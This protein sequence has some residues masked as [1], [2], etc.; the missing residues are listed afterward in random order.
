MFVSLSLV[1]RLGSELTLMMESTEPSA[2]LPGR[3][4]SVQNPSSNSSK[5]PQKASGKENEAAVTTKGLLAARNPQ[6]PHTTA[7]DDLDT[8]QQHQRKTQLRLNPISARV[9]F[10]FA[11]AVLKKKIWRNIPV[12]LLE[13]RR[14][15]ICLLSGDMVK[16]SLP[17]IF[18]ISV[19][20][21]V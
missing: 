15:F 6:V 5:H 20:E 4:D 1:P 9:G 21:F 2:Q 13:R 3:R 19:W 7:S 11:A 8:M 12:T 16:L 18:E 10:L 17:I 14:K